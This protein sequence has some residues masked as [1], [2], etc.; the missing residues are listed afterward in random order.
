MQTHKGDSR[1]KLTQGRNG[2]NIMGNLLW[3]TKY[4][5]F[6]LKRFPVV[7]SLTLPGNGQRKGRPTFPSSVYKKKYKNS[8]LLTGD[9]GGQR[10][11]HTVLKL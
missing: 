4:C 8:Y 1:R 5:L 7:S 3:W 10:F 6:V 2:V 9:L 11:P